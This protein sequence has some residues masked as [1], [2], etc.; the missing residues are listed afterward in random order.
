MPKGGCLEQKQLYYIALFHLFASANV[1]DDAD[2]TNDSSSASINITNGTFARDIYTPLTSGSSGSLGIGAGNLGYVGNSYTL[3]NS[4]NLTSVTFAVLN[5][6]GIL[7]GVDVRAA[8]FE[9]TA[10]GAPQF[11]PFAYTDYVTIGSGQSELYTAQISGG[12]VN[13]S[14]G[15][16][17]VALVEETAVSSSVAPTPDNPEPSPTNLLAVATPV[18]LIP[19]APVRFLLLGRVA[20]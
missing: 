5:G 7:E 2:S 18:I 15:T 19:P 3:T 9:T 11:T 16:Y 12:G 8:I 6:D 17:V 20:P 14:S 10:T 13:L 4:D 1:P